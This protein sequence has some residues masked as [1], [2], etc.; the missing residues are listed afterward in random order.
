MSALGCVVPE[1]LA[2]PEP[3]AWIAMNYAGNDQM[4]WILPL[5]PVFQE[6]GLRLVP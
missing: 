6:L 2:S 4:S 3:S 1:M 5:A